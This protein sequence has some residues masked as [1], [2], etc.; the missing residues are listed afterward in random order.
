MPRFNE[1]LQDDNFDNDEFDIDA[2][3]DALLAP[4]E[5]APLVQGTPSV[6]GNNEEF[7]Q[8]LDEQRQQ[9]EL[10][11]QRFQLESSRQ[12]EAQRNQQRAFQDQ[13]RVDAIKN[14]VQSFRPQFVE[15]QLDEETR[16]AYKGA[17]PYI[18]A[19][20]DSALK[21][22]W[23]KHIIPALTHYETELEQVKTRPTT[24]QTLSTEDRVQ[25]M[26]PEVSTM[27]KEADF[28]RF[29]SEPVDGTGMTRKELMNFAY[30]KGNVNSVVQQL[31]TYASRKSQAK[32]QRSV[33]MTSGM[34]SAPT[35]GARQPK[36]R[37]I[38]ELSNAQAKFRMGQITRDKLDAIEN[39][40]E[41]L[42]SRSL[43]DYNK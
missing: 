26:R 36:T 6:A 27:I 13:Q 2:E 40:F 32:P 31:D 23:D 3:L 19:M 21:E 39:L 37:G 38:S 10:D 15:H 41:D 42:A 18:R 14:R 8:F 33:Q 29:L 20:V 35:G 30:E 43:V 4:T 24:A 12:E 5:A 28:Q 22:Q 16:T 7:R 34:H 1:E 9:R 17:D 11:R 25:L